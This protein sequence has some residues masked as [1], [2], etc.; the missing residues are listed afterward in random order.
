LHQGHACGQLFGALLS[1]GIRARE[2][3]DADDAR[4]A[5]ALH[6]AR[7]LAAAFSALD[8]STDCRDNVGP[9]ITLL[10][11]IRYLRSDRPRACG[12]T[13]IP[14]AAE[15]ADVIDGALDELD[16]GALSN[17]QRNCAVECMRRIAPAGGLEEGDA[18]LVAGFAGGL[19]L[20]GN[21]CGALAAGVF[22]LTARHYRGRGPEQ[23]DSKLRG[24]LQEL[25]LI[26]G[27]RAEPARLLEGFRRSFA[28]ELCRQMVGR[29]FESA[30]DHSTFIAEGGCQ[31][32][33]EHVA[34]QARSAMA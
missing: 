31:D 21:A 19:G 22:A 20:L 26:S 2:R 24:A 18:V 9:L 17:P 3:F 16:P 8:W 27:L 5:A 29:R 14:W 10:D 4:A 13:I 11:R 15:A 33:I 30:E 28:S 12:R 23:R 6:A 32:V 25:N 7:A 34:A 1:A